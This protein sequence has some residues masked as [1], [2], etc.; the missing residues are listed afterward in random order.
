MRALIVNYLGV[1]F[2][3]DGSGYLAMICTII[4]L[5]YFPQ[6]RKYIFREKENSVIFAS[7]TKHQITSNYV[8]R[9]VRYKL[10]VPGNIF[11]L[12]KK[13]YY[14]LSGFFFVFEIVALCVGISIK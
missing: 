13:R 3:F 12:L 10:P 1:S 7:Q 8:Y 2:F 4:A 11:T 5:H 9:V 14:L 6:I